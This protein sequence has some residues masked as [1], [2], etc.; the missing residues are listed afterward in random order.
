[1]TLGNGTYAEA[2]DIVTQPDSPHGQA[3]NIAKTLFQ[4]TKK[5][6]TTE[7]FLSA[8]ELQFKA[9]DQ[10]STIRKSNLATFLSA[11]FGSEEIGFFPLNE[12]F[13]DTFVPDGGR[14]LK[15]Q[16]SLYLDL[17]TQAYI[18]AISAN[19]QCKDEILD[20][21]FPANMGEILMSRRGGGKQLPPSE[22]DF[23]NRLGHRRSHL[24]RFPAEVSLTDN[25]AWHDFLK[26]ISGY[27]NKY[28]ETF[29]VLPSGNSQL[30][31]A[32]AGIDC[33][34]TKSRQKTASHGAPHPDMTGR[35]SHH[36]T[37]QSPLPLSVRHERLA[38]PATERVS[39][40]PVYQTHSADSHIQPNA[41]TGGNEQATREISPDDKLF[42]P[43]PSFAGA[44]PLA[45]LPV[46]QQW[47]PT[48]VLYERARLAAASSYPA[49]AR[50][51]SLKLQRHPW[52]NEEETALM[53]A[54]DIVKGPHWA[55]ILALFGPG[56]TISEALK[57][58]NQVQLKDKARNLKLFFLKSGIEVP[59]HLQCVTGDLKTRAHG[60]RGGG[61]PGGAAEAD[62]GDDGAHQEAVSVFSN[63]HHQEVLAYNHISS[64]D[65]GQ[66]SVEDEG[67]SS[68]QGECSELSCVT[69]AGVV[70]RGASSGQA[71]QTPEVICHDPRNGKERGKA[72][73]P[74]IALGIETCAGSL[75]IHE[76]QV[77]GQSPVIAAAHM[78]PTE[79]GGDNQQIEDT[80]DYPLFSL[81]SG[82]LDM[83]NGA[84]SGPVTDRAR[85]V[86]GFGLGISSDEFFDEFMANLECEFPIQFA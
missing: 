18:S 65:L 57:D 69:D 6:Y 4:Q 61:T 56:G 73:N 60:R 53:A 82:D 44:S 47:L 31:F 17:K 51:S 71:I 28:H 45:E 10:R 12:H 16:G 14:L 79:V 13:L 36:E 3:Y 80:V 77:I 74:E 40:A 1:M 81:A 86:S 70:F 2:L 22:Q 58:R 84:G 46:P 41:Q 15:P 67:G 54:L 72:Q 11:V 75:S 32:T 52:T 29:V 24:I 25:Y 37:P 34:R 42:G 64:E 85:V 8:D 9:I 39:L 48:K 68:D 62:E 33:T 26:G 63:A 23:V 19:E 59:Y 78:A 5:T 30:H 50:R 20:N 7:A 21:L 35:P 66:P 83:R 76:H 27:V 38:A 49:I 55:Q 43:S